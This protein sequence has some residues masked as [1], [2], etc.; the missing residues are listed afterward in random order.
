MYP[1]GFR[2]GVSSTVK[3]RFH[4]EVNYLSTYPA[5]PDKGILG[6]AH[7]TLILFKVDTDRVSVV[8][9]NPVFGSKN[10]FGVSSIVSDSDLIILLQ[11]DQIGTLLYSVLRKEVTLYNKVL[12][13][14]GL[15]S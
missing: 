3:L 7:R 15:P 9:R 4:L 8:K 11:D 6:R 5:S 1:E 13:C 10:R 2:S 12:S 14:C